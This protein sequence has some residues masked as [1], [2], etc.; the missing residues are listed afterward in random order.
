M[1]SKYTESITVLKSLMEIST[2]LDRKA[3]VL[4]KLFKKDKFKNQF[5]KSEISTFLFGDKDFIE[6]WRINGRNVITSD[7]DLLNNYSTELSLLYDELPAIF[8]KKGTKTKLFCVSNLIIGL[9][10]KMANLTY[11][12]QETKNYLA[13]I[14][15]TYH[16]YPS[17]QNKLT[18]AKRFQN[19]VD[20]YLKVEKITKKPIELC[21]RHQMENERKEILREYWLSNF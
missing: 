12:T 5:T 15:I 10:K 8:K 6:S 4:E 3:I 19:F 16:F 13:D 7:K 14:F 9:K 1:I 20:Y 11:V 2:T 21:S 17:S 18:L